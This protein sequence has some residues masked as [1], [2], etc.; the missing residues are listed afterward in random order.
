MV[1]AR[2]AALEFVLFVTELFIWAYLTVVD[3]SI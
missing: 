2:N 3:I 1:Q